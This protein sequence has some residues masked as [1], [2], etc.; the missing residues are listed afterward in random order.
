M[1]Q[2]KG[3]LGYGYVNYSYGEGRKT[4]DSQILLKFFLV[5]SGMS[6]KISCSELQVLKTII[7]WTS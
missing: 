7:H 5:M 4:A 2:E 1:L 3:V 6:D